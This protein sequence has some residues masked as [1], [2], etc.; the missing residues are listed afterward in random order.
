[1][2]AKAEFVEHGDRIG[3]RNCCGVWPEYSVSKIAISP[4]TIWA[5]LSP[6]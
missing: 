6:R 1:M 2:F 4:R 3:A 5:S